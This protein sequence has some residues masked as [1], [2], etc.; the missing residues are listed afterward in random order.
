MCHACLQAKS[1]GNSE[2]IDRLEVRRR[3]MELQQRLV[4]EL[5]ATSSVPVCTIV[6]FSIPTL[7]CATSFLELNIWLGPLPFACPDKH[8][9]SGN[10]LSIPATSRPGWCWSKGGPLGP[11]SSRNDEAVL[12]SGA[13]LSMG[14]QTCRSRNMDTVL[15]TLIDLQPHNMQEGIRYW[16][17]QSI[18]WQLI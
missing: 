2:V 13:H 9:V 15:R 14:H 11:L 17:C 3:L 18:V 10:W 4:A 1:Q 6:Q 8:S 16:A 7:S 12:L 5:E